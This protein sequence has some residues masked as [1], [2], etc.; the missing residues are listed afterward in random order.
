MRAA[1]VEARAALRG[2]ESVQAAE[3]V[4]QVRVQ[5]SAQEQARELS[6][7]QELPAPGRVLAVPKRR[8]QSALPV[9]ERQVPEP[10]REEQQPFPAA[11]PPPAAQ[12]SASKGL[13]VTSR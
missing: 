5:E 11:V 2:Q 1:Q 7:V 6:Q 10:K 12:P 3:P 4:A 8:E 9:R 13:N